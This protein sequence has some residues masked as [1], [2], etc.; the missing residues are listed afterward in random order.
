MD[1][2]RIFE[3]LNP[4]QRRAV[5]TV[6]GP[7]CILAGAGSGKTTTITRRIA[8]Q[9][10]SGAFAA[11]EILAVTFTDKAAGEMRARLEALGVKGVE[12]RTFHS[13]AYA[14]LRALAAG[15]P[16]SVL[17]SKALML[18]HIGNRLPRPYRFRPAGDLATE[19]EW[20][21][22]RRLAPATYR[23]G[24]GSHE[25]PI[26]VELMECV[27][28]E[29]ER[30]KTAL[31]KV[32]FEDLLEHAIRLLDDPHAR[33]AVHERYRA[34]T[35][36]E[37][38][39]VNL[40]QQTLLERWLGERDDVCVVGD[41][42][43]SIYSFIGATPEHLLSTPKRF[44]A[45]EVIRLEANY[46]S[47][48][49]ILGLANRLVPRLGGAEK[50]LRATRASGPLPELRA[51]AAGG[52]AAVV[53]ERVRAL[54]AAGVDDREMAILYRTNARSAEWEEALAAAGIPFTV[55]AGAFL[56]RQAARRLLGA[57]RGSSG[58][59][60]GATVR[61]LAERDGL[62]V[63]PPERLG[64]QEA[65]RQADL[66]LLVELARELDDGV[67]TLA[68]FASEV[69]RRFGREASG[70][71]VNLLTYHAA[72]GLEFDAVFLPRLEEGQVPSK[73]ARSAAAVAEERRLL[74]VG[75]T[76]ARSH[77]CVTWR[78]DAKPSRFL[79]ELGVATTSRG[80]A[81]PGRPEAAEVDEPAFRA[82]RSW[83]LRRAKADGVPA[84]VVFH[85]S[86]LAEIVRRAPGS[87]EELATVPGVGPAKLERY[88]GEVLATLRSAS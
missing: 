83:R 8:N 58:T 20:A 79:A 39:D 57:V 29:Y 34:F 38:Q 81:R 53:L 60:V 32:D 1:R 66:R 4:E 72:K 44:P 10:A 43:Q 45:A 7:V 16:G 31:G 82:L 88:A 35:V 61:E 67:L 54:R 18:R 5:E 84:Y 49:E 28:A 64:E 62:L 59:R 68:G 9:V 27:F 13:A 3:R 78:G 76:R 41:D 75:L 51:V 63:R 26:P 17:P 42:Y 47:T 46:R 52:E 33:T 85:D 71:G 56:E 24:L 22:S 50:T 14:Q 37:Y 77:L 87:P 48:P 70:R 36:D 25:P 80:A 40:L 15:P 55:R 74:Y 2:E 12:A 23:R 65:V 86:T 11:G 21:K 30:R 19:I 69:E 6:R 73:L